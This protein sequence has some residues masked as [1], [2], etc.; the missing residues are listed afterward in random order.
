MSPYHA[1]GIDFDTT[2]EEVREAYLRLVREHPPERDPEHFRFIQQA[3]GEIRLEV[4]RLRRAAL[5]PSVGSQPKSMEQALVEHCRYGA[6]QAFP[7]PE[8][9]RAALRK[10]LLA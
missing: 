4:D 9:F 2:D 7:E 5:A 8:M 1:L 3:Y 6:R 10:Q